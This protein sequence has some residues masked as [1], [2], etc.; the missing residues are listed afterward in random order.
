MENVMTHRRA[1]VCFLIAILLSSLG[2]GTD[3]SVQPI[4][5]GRSNLAFSSGG[6][7]APVFDINM[8]MPY[9]VLRYR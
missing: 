1:A 4:G 8:P 7:V 3:A 6:P 5:K 9:S 2:C